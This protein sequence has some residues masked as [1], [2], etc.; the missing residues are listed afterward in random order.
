VKNLHIVV[1]LALAITASAERQWTWHNGPGVMGPVSSFSSY[2]LQA[3]EIWSQKMYEITLAAAEITT[4]VNSYN[5]PYMSASLDFDNDGDL[6]VALSSAFSSSSNTITVWENVGGTGSIWQLV[7]EIETFCGGDLISAD[8][9]G[10]LFDDLIVGQFDPSE[11]SY[12]LWIAN[13]DGSGQSWTIHTI[14]DEFDRVHGVG[15]ADFDQDG[16]LDVAGIS[17]WKEKVSW[18]ENLDGQGT[19]WATHDIG[20][21]LLFNNDIEVAD[22][23]GDDLIDVAVVAKGN[24]SVYWF[25]NP[26]SLPDP[27]TRRTVSSCQS[28]RIC[29][30]DIDCDGDI[31]L[32][33]TPV[34]Q[35]GGNFVVWFN[36]GTGESW[37]ETE[38]LDTDWTPCD[39]GIGD[40]DSDGDMDLFGCGIT[41]SDMDWFIN[42]DGLGTTWGV[43]TLAS[44]F[45]DCFDCTALDANGDG[46][47]DIMAY[48]NNGNVFWYNLSEDYAS[49]GYLISS[50]LDVLPDP[51]YTWVSWAG[52]VPAGTSVELQFR[53]SDSYQSMGE[54]SEPICESPYPA[55]SLINDGD[56]YFQYR[57]NMFT[58][59]PAITP[60]VNSVTV[61]WSLQGIEGEP[62]EISCIPLANPARGQFDLQVVLPEEMDLAISVFDCAGRLQMSLPAQRYPSGENVIN[63]GTFPAGLY[64]CQVNTPDKLINLTFTCIE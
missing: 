57:V 30:G 26:G 15:C 28:N 7:A 17:Y 46:E 29:A 59:D 11:D 13:D 56:R 24:S 4:V 41:L 19:D 40:F 52:S 23:N 37:E 44:N 36:N 45:A 6:D 16:D 54:W 60:E 31:D 50:I 3:Q 9:N 20:N 48:Y 43:R 22:F 1:L 38:I 8:I 63:I 12:I 10:D 64:L 27:W 53:S 32:A 47:T 34:D 61:V 21:Y 42:L 2:Y 58:S 35:E 49:E 14:D 62:L 39:V 5:D 33:A 25:E 55:D 51:D 18:F